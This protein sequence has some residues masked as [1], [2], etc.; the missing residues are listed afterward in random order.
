MFHFSFL[1]ELNGEGGKKVWVFLRN[2]LFPLVSEIFQCRIP[3][4]E[5]AT[6]ISVAFGF[7]NSAVV[8][9]V[10]YSL[11]PSLVK[12]TEMKESFILFPRLSDF[13]FVQDLPEREKRKRILILF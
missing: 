6:S 13:F 3:S 2:F 5:W 10:L 11:S 12:A 8:T 9:H 1:W 7:P 4:A